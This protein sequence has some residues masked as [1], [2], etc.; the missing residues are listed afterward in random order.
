MNKKAELKVSGFLIALLLIGM[1]AT[2]YSLVMVDLTYINDDNNIVDPFE[3]YNMTDMIEDAKSIKDSSTIEQEEGFLD[4]I[5]GF[6]SSGYG[7]LKTSIKSFNLFENMMND[8]SDEVP[9]LSIY[10]G[11]IVTIIIILIFVGVI[12]SALLKMRV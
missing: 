9:I 1:I 6:F 2:T 10:K 5:G 12:I 7:A 11:F 8:A 3:K 4:V